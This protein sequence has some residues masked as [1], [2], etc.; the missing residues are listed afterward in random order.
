M[1][2]MP[3]W[4]EPDEAITT[5]WETDQHQWDLAVLSTNI[6][7]SDKIQGFRENY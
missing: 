4:S 7:S 6:L 1:N 3:L 2:R 5:D